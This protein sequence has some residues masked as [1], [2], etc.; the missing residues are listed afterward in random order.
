[1]RVGSELV[2]KVW[3]PPRR[4]VA[5]SKEQM[6]PGS[7]TVADEWTVEAKSGGTCRVRVV[8]SCFASA[9]DW[10]DQFEAVEKGWPAFFRILNVY[11]AHFRGQPSEIIPLMAMS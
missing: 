3:N 6:G 4:F 1:A 10:D 2:I 11:L 5:E 9:D 8:H 7:P